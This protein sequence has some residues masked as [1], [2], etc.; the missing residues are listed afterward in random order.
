MITKI[1]IAALFVALIAA[2]FIFDL[3]KYFSLESLKSQQELLNEFYKENAVLMIV[4]FFL[5]YVLF[6]ALALPAASFLTF[7][8]GALFGL[9][10]GVIIVSFASTIGATIS[11]LFSRYL[12]HD[13]IEAKFGNK[14]EAVNAGIE[15]DGAFYVFGLRFMPFIPFFVIN[16]LLGLTKLKTF[17]FY[18]ASQLGMLAGTIVYVN[19]GTQI[20]DIESLDDLFSFKLLVSFVL[21]GVFPIIAKHIMNFIQRKKEANASV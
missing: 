19:F 6:A 7:A 14:L 8:A 9:W 15:K 21:L 17:T 4:G 16:P 13:A 11:F 1:I 12:L 10:I 3:G 20:A 5:L 2:F 18:W